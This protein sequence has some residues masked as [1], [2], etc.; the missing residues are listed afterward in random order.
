MPDSRDGTSPTRKQAWFEQPRFLAPLVL[1]FVALYAVALLTVGG[2][3]EEEPTALSGLRAGE[4]TAGGPSDAALDM[5]EEPP[6][7]EQV[8]PEP[9]PEDP[10]PPADAG[11]ADAAPPPPPEPDPD[12]VAAPGDDTTLTDGGWVVESFELRQDFAG[13]FEGVARIRN[14]E[15]RNPEAGFS[16]IIRDGDQVV[17]TLFGFGTGIAPGQTQEVTFVGTTPYRA[18]DYSVEFRW[19]F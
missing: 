6:P 14:E 1:V 3:D 5:L 8:D 16:M 12:R 13:D 10:P 9:M 4:A 15:A 7:D 11:E 19:D 18:G 17:T 2:E